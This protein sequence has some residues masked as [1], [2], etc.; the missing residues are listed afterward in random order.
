[1]LEKSES[2]TQKSIHGVDREEW[3]KKSYAGFYIA[4]VS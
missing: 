4:I 2:M 1:M 3:K